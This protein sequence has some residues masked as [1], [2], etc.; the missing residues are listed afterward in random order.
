MLQIFPDVRLPAIWLRLKKVLTDQPGRQSY[1][2]RLTE[3]WSKLWHE[4]RGTEELPDEH[5]NSNTEFD[6]RAHLVYLRQNISKQ[7]L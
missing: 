6:L 4:K 3:A 7:S 5:P 1:L 2:E